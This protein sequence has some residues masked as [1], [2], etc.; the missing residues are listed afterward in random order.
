MSKRNLIGILGLGIFGRTI[1]ET[2]SEYDV[3]VIAIEKDPEIANDYRSLFTET[4]IGD[5]RDKDLLKAVGIDE[6]Q[7]VVVAAGS[8]LE[9]SSIA[10]LHLSELGV[11]MVVCKSANKISS[12]ILKAIGA[13]KVINPEEETGRRLGKSLVQEE[14]T[15][16]LDLDDDTSLIDFK[17]PKTWHGKRLDEL[18]LRNKYKIN[19]IGY[20]EKDNKPLNTNVHASTILNENMT[21]VGIANDKDIEEYEF[22]NLK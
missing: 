19:I 9:A 16:I 8:N 10:V 13:T 15:N 1:G 21:L 5:F 12:K 14:V 6:C 22:L 3:D 2:L 18:D 7:A 20:R 4:V 17:L 11:P